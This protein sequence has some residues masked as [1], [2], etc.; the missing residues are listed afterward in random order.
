MIISYLIFI[1]SLMI[2][3]SQQ[4]ETWPIQP[5]F[6]MLM[7]RRLSGKLL[8]MILTENKQNEEKRKV[9]LLQKQEREEQTCKIIN[10]RLMALTQGSN[11]LRDFF[12]SRY[13]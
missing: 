7:T 4:T 2:Q 10:E 9:E 3:S 11:F 8:T 12:S 13:W 5:T 1:A 6:N